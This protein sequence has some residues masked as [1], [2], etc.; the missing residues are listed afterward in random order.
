MNCTGTRPTP[1]SLR[2]GMALPVLG[3]EDPGEV[4]VPG[5]A[6]A[7]HVVGL[8]LHGFGPAVEIPQRRHLGSVLGHLHPE[9]DPADLRQRQ[10][11]HHQLEA[12]G[13]DP[14]RKGAPGVSEI[15]HGGEIGEHLEPGVAMRGDHVVIA[16]T[17]G[18]EQVMA[19]HRRRSGH[20]GERQFDR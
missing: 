11:H 15:V 7:V 10:E 14:V 12:L 1:K 20:V 17:A 16:V 3:H 4:G 2:S 18:E 19:V 13:R 5:E 9:A 6:D 8:A